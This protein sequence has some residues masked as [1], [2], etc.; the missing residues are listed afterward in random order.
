MTMTSVH[1]HRF[2]CGAVVAVSTRKIDGISIAECVG[3]LPDAFRTMHY[4][5]VI[6]SEL[7][8]GGGSDAGFHEFI[9]ALRDASEEDTSAIVAPRSDRNP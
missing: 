8:P 7:P 4:G 1:A 6:H 5:P 9:T 2:P 3:P